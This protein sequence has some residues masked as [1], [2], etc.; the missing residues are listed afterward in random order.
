MIIHQRV[1]KLSPGRIALYLLISFFVVWFGMLIA[2]EIDSG[3]NLITV[4]TKLNS[5]VSNPFYIT[6]CGSTV[7]TVIICLFVYGFVLAI[8]LTDDKNYRRGEEYGSARW[9]IPAVINNKYANKRHPL[10]NLILTQ[11]VRMSLDGWKTKRNLNLFVIGGAGAGKTRHLAMPNIMQCNTSF[12]V[13]DPKGEITAKSGHLLEKNGYKI[14]VIDLWHMERSL[15][16]NPFVYIRNDDDIQLLATNLFKNTT[17]KGS[18]TQDPFWD[19][20]AMLLLKALMFYLYYEAPPEEQN[21]P[22]IMEMIRAGDV[23]EDDDDYKSPLDV[24]FDE[25]KEKSP[26]HIAYKCYKGYH[27]GSGKTLKSIQI[28]LIARLEKFDLPSLAGMTQ[29]DE[30]E[31][32]TM[33]E[34]KTVLYLIL[35]VNDSSYNFIVGML[36]TQLIQQ[37]YDNANF[38]HGGRLPIHVHFLMDE[39]ANVALPDEFDKTLATMRSMEISVTIIVQ[40]LAQLKKLYEKEW[41]S[42]IANCDELLYLGGNEYETFEYISKRLGKETVDTDNYS[43]T[44]GMHGSWTVNHQKVG[45]DLMS[46]DQVAKLPDEKAILFIKGQDP[47]VDDKY[48]LLKHPNCKFT[49]DGGGPSYIHNRDTMSVNTL[50][51]VGNVPEERSKAVDIEELVDDE[52]ELMTHDFEI[53]NDEDLDEIYSEKGE[54]S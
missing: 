7:K 31:L 50:A 1:N 45:V 36:Y 28:S 42:I 24:L 3:G 46:P 44:K 23:K 25:L 49:P 53:L 26:N 15:S 37:L 18:Q 35:P 21:F 20:T 9:G 38:K 22:M 34:Q 14:K 40:A 51:L 13:T 10:E 32:S 6:I 8:Y 48:D 11:H 29:T 27:S 47:I 4:L 41:G 33:G 19:Q 52:D 16:Y 2:P 54:K 39:F 30:L 43:Q 5:L 12:V 17:P